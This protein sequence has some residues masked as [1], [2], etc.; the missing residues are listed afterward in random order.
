M[1][2]GIDLTLEVVRRVDTGHRANGD[3]RI[4]HLVYVSYLVTPFWP[5]ESDDKVGI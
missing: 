4:N 3:I 2:K 1:F 5:G